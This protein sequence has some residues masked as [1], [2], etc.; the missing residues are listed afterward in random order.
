MLL[1][2]NANATF[3]NATIFVLEFG[4]AATASQPDIMFS[5]HSLLSVFS[6]HNNKSHIC[7]CFFFSKS[8]LTGGALQSVLTGGTLQSVLTGGALQSVLRGG[9][10][11]SV[12]RGGALVCAD[13]W[14]TTVCA[15]R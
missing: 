9:A 4:E 3:S 14:R 8:V 7:R 15:E 6:H 11:Q 13:R 2:L 12:L 10:L 5:V 1:H